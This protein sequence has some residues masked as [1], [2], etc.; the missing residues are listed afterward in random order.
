MTMTDIHIQNLRKKGIDVQK[1]IVKS[2]RLAKNYSDK[3]KESGKK[4]ET[5]Q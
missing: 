1:V 5:N 3:I 2:L 4:T